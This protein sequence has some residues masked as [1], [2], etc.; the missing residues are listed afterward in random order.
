[1]EQQNVKIKDFLKDK[2]KQRALIALK[3]KKFLEKEIDKATGAQQML[4]QTINNIESAQ[5]DVNV[6]DALKVG[7]QVI[8]ELQNK[9]KLEDFQELYER[10]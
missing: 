8:T 5:M 3:H 10:H 4:M 2:A 9:A 1:M 6:M 7:D